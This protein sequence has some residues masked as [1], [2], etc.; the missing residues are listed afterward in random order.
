[1]VPAHNNGQDL[2]RCLAALAEDQSGPACE[3]IV[4]DDGSTEDLGPIASA[5]R[6]RLLRLADNAGPA[7]ARN[8]GA[9]QARGEI[10]LFVDADVVVGRGTLRRVAEILAARPGVAAVFGSYDAR[11][12]APAV[13]SQYRNLLHH[14]VHQTGSVEAST[15]WAGC[16]AVRRAVFEEVGGFDA[17]RYRAP[18]IE[19]IE[20]G[21]R[22]RAAG[23]RVRLEPALQ[24][25]H[26][27]R[28]TLASMVRTDVLRR[29]IPWSRLILE[30]RHAP[31][32]LNLRRDQR[33]GVALTGAGAIALV[34]A[35]W[36]PAVALG[37]VAAAGGVVAI[38]HRLFRFFHRERGPVFALA[39]IPLHLL[40]YLGSGAGFMAAWIAAHL[41]ARQSG[42]RPADPRP[43]VA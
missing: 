22:L 18:S 6:V 10:L 13:V 28:W 9:R 8:H 37:A 41:S 11:P 16:G 14:Y 32:D 38:N 5:P 30:R 20:L 42:G 39:C 29:A 2:R 27:K 24:V 31:D 35:L 23:H 12:S 4:V 33:L 34:A 40:H 19:D 21:Y 7:A 43:R 1:V 36:Q 3:I 26:L 25:T 15:F 17:E